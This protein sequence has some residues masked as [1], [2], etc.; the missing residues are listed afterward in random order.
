[1]IKCLH[2]P[3]HSLPNILKSDENPDAKKIFQKGEEKN[4]GGVQRQIWL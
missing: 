2:I 1:M 3:S 4:G